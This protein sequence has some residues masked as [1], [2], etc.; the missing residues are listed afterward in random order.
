MT[1]QNYKAE[2]SFSSERALRVFESLAVNLSYA[3][4]RVPSFGRLAITLTLHKN[5]AVRQLVETE[6]FY[7]YS[8]GSTGDDS[9]APASDPEAVQ[10]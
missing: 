6:Y 3:L 2:I 4:E 10:E 1:E 8:D 7:R 5:R 9:R